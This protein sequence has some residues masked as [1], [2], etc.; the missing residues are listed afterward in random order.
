MFKRFFIR[1]AEPRLKGSD[2]RA[3]QELMEA[4]YRA[5]SI[6]TNT[7]TSRPF[8]YLIPP[9]YYPIPHP[10]SLETATE[11]DF[12]NSTTTATFARRPTTIR[13][14][15]RLLGG[16]WAIP[17]V[18]LLE[19]QPGV[20]KTRLLKRLG[21]EYEYEL[22]DGARQGS[23]RDALPTVVTRQRADASAHLDV[24]VVLVLT[25]NARRNRLELRCEDKN[26]F[27]V[28]DP[29]LF[30]AFDEN[31][32]KFTLMRTVRRGSREAQLMKVD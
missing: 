5:L 12:V 26:R 18:V 6:E 32:E 25:H 1:P 20:G 9:A 22:I 14:I 29:D 15:D 11:G 23:E 31:H 28:V 7:D 17:S 3:R 24:D 2:I 8:V 13:A 19:G 10:D 21:I 27:G 30:V 16:G 4:A